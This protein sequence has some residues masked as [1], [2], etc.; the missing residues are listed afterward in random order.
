MIIYTGSWTTKENFV[1]LSAENV[2]RYIQKEKKGK[3]ERE[4]EKTKQV[5][6][7]K[8]IGNESF[9]GVSFVSNDKIF[10]KMIEC[11]LDELSCKLNENGDFNRKF[12]ELKL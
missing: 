6:E 5:W 3:V 10:S 12:K 4:E 9:G 11:S 1:S 2:V 8:V 7:L